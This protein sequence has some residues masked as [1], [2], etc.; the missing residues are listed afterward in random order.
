MSLSAAD[1]AAPVIL[2]DPASWDPWYDQ[3]R[4]TVPEQL[5]TYFSPDSEEDY[6]VPQPPVKP[7]DEVPEGAEPP[8]QRNAREARNQRRQDVYF[9]LYSIYRDEKKEWDQFNAAKAKLRT[10][11]QNTTAK[12]RRSTLQ[13]QYSVRQ[14]FKALQTKIALPVETIRRN[15]QS[16]YRRHVGV[17]YLEWPSGGPTTWLAKWEDL[18]TRADRYG[19]PLPM[20]LREVSMVWERV[21]ALASYFS[22]ISA[23]II[24]NNTD[25]YT[26]NLLSAMIKNFYEMRKQ[27]SSLRL[28]N[29][30]RA[31]R[32]AFATQGVT[33]DGEEAP[34]SA[35]AATA[36]TTG[37]K[38]KGKRG[39]KS[40]KSRPIKRSQSLKRS[41][42]Q[43]RSKTPPPA[44]S[45]RRQTRTRT[46]PPPAQ[47]TRSLLAPSDNRSRSRSPRLGRPAKRDQR[48]APRDPCSACG[49]NSHNFD[50]CFLVL[51]TERPWIT[52][53]SRET[54]RENLK[55]ADFKKKVEDA[56]AN[57]Q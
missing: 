6:P 11:I 20:W 40:G 4:A 2:S 34:E 52:D 33:Y 30:P 32:S 24:I 43:S 44:H 39:R 55:K 54:F 5:W 16:D 21:P 48:R 49:G 37:T 19:E 31:T 17:A 10:Q 50:R 12:E 22:T 1:A 28:M 45:S 42:S 7:I 26:P 46:P 38:G 27:S 57:H 25:Q 29:R 53:E 56:R 18:L 41:R 51:G 47:S 8:N 23:N 15:I 36:D 3:T 9:K 35:A 14:W 13:P